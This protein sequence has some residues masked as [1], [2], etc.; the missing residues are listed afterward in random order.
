MTNNSLSAFSVIQFVLIL[1]LIFCCWPIKSK[2]CSSWKDKVKNKNKKC[3]SI[4]RRKTGSWTFKSSSNPSWRWNQK[5][6]HSKV[7]FWRSRSLITTLT[8]TFARNL[9]LL[10]F[11]QRNKLMINYS[12]VDDIVPSHEKTLNFLEFFTLKFFF[13][14]LVWLTQ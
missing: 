6:F 11:N 5:Y 1:R 2:F 10:L 4:I 13:K 7:H 9:F 8:K 14:F 12:F 3:K